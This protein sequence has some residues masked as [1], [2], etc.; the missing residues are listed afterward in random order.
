MRYVGNIVIFPIFVVPNGLQ[1][2]IGRAQSHPEVAYPRQPCFNALSYV[3]PGTGTSLSTGQSQRKRARQSGKLK[4]MSDR[5][6]N[7][8]YVTL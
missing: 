4:L 3:T 6:Q 7:E 8:S 2:G 1:Q 5:S